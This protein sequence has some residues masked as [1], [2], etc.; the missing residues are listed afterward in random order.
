M[1]SLRANLSR[2]T[3]AERRGALRWRVELILSAG[4][5]HDL[6]PVVVRNLSEKGLMLQTEAT[7]E[8]GEEIVV[9]LPGAEDTRARVEWRQEFCYGCE[10]LVPISS[11][12]VENT[13]RPAESKR[14][15]FS[16][17]K[18]AL[19][20]RQAT[21]RAAMSM[22]SPMGCESI[23]RMRIRWLASRLASSSLDIEFNRRKEGV[24]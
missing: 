16:R 3:S 15:S 17:L 14:R 22:A 1:K 2:L 9:E 11:A 18:S 23:C 21:S 5:E 24:T 12:A 7:L 20:S 6:S 19:S 10:F 13:I 4:P 8:V